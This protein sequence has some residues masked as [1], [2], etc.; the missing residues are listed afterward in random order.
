MILA[1]FERLRVGRGRKLRTCPRPDRSDQARLSRARP[2]RHRSARDRAAARSFPA[3]RIPRR[4]SA[5][6]RHEE[7]RALAGAGRARATRSGWARPTA[8]ASSSPISSRSIGNSAPA[9][10]LPR[11]GLADAKSRRELLARSEGAST[12]SSPDGCRST[13]SIPALAVLKDG[14]VMAYGTMGGDGQ[15]QTQA[16]LFTRHVLY[17][18][19]LARGAR[20][21]RAGCSAAPGARRR[22]ICGWNPASTAICSTGCRRPDMTW[23]CCRKPYS[24]RWAMPARS[25]CIPTARS[26]A[27]TIRAP[28][29]AR[30]GLTLLE[31]GI[32][33]PITMLRA[34]IPPQSVICCC[35]GASPVETGSF[36]CF[37]AFC[38]IAL[39]GDCAA[40]RRRVRVRA[41]ACLCDDEERD[42]LCAGRPHDRH[43]PCLDLRRHVL[44]LCDAGAREQSRRAVHARGTGSR[45]PRSTSPR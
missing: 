40:A 25:F 33:V 41:S 15:P 29:A 22:P 44:D 37:T 14:R 10:V 24:D 34:S 9:C 43:P 16:A 8:T 36:P 30:R 12:R 17:R 6:D 45:S 28:M 7:G 26:K 18:Q 42:R 27:R 4:R 39:R 35:A 19:P 11:T 2:L 3:S 32:L 38:R 21:A 23:R 5:E 31:R 1:L 20:R 13:R